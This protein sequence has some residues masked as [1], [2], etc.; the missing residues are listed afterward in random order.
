MCVCVMAEA[1]RALFAYNARA[2]DGQSARGEKKALVSAYI[3]AHAHIHASTARKRI[4]L[5]RSTKHTPHGGRD[6]RPEPRRHTHTQNK[7]KQQND[8]QVAIPASNSNEGNIVSLSLSMRVCVCVS[9]YVRRRIR[10]QGGHEARRGK[11]NKR[12]KGE[13]KANHT[14]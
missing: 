13:G 3:H 6:E 10:K 8:D 7:T 1:T 9:W 12:E 4:C 14:K 11:R 5:S 2:P